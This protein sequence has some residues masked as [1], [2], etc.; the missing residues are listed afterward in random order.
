MNKFVYFVGLVSCIGVV[1]WR[2]FLVTKYMILL[3]FGKL[4]VSLLERP[5]I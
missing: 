2:Q 5:F 4:V 1:N 3:N